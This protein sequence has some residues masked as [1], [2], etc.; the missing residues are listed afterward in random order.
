MSKYD[1]STFI[2]LVI[3]YII[4]IMLLHFITFVTFIMLVK[5]VQTLYEG[6][7]LY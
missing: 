6:L 3:K 1:T 4:K 7:K 2:T 5:S